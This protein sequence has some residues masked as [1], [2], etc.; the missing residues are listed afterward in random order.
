MNHEIDKRLDGKD[1]I[2]DIKD[3]RLINM[4]KIQD[5]KDRY[6]QIAIKNKRRILTQQGSKDKNK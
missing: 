1:K 6:K 4:N 2:S 3:N 5:S